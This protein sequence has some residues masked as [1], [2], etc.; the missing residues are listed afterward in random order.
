MTQRPSSGHT[1]LAFERTA[2]MAVGQ[3]VAT[4]LGILASRYIVNRFGVEKLRTELWSRLGSARIET[5]GSGPSQRCSV[6]ASSSS[7]PISRNTGRHC[8]QSASHRRR[9]AGQDLSCRMAVTTVDREPQLSYRL[10]SR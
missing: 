7:T 10:A 6:S 9:Q 8:D 3:Q 5:T 1:Y 4:P 2:T